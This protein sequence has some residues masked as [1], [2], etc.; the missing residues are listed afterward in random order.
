MAK[1]V[2]V[3]VDARDFQ[4][5]LS[6]F[7]NALDE[8][9]AKSVG[10]QVI[11]KMKQLITKGISPIENHGRFPEYKAQKL[12][13]EAAEVRKGAKS[14]AQDFGK[15]DSQVKGDRAFAR[16][17]SKQAKKSYP[18]T[19]IGK[20]PSKRR[21]P[22]N[23]ELSGKFLDIGLEAWV[24]GLKDKFQVDVGFRKKPYIDYERGHR[25]QANGQGF[26]P[27]IPQDQERFV[28]QIRTIINSLLKDAINLYANRKR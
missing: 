11:I 2:K 10:D 13:K 7:G 22:V 4:D 16:T 1:R 18:D 28:K 20:F 21:R 25:E 26:R 8:R 6:E 14:R 9:V 15:K 3:T 17:L 24:R 5:L 19:V 27:I 12:A 23:L